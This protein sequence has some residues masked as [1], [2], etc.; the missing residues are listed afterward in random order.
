VV[1]IGSARWRAFWYRA[2]GVAPNSQLGDG[3]NQ[4]DVPLQNVFPFHAAPH[5]GW[6]HSQIDGTNGKGMA[7]Q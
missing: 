2:F 1:D 5:A 4:N 7:T 6:K 3:V